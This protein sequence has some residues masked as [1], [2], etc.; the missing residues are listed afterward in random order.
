MSCFAKRQEANQYATSEHTV[1]A[2][3]P[4]ARKFTLRMGFALVLGASLTGCAVGPKY[5]RPTV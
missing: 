4:A 1:F 3:S 5:H 2:S